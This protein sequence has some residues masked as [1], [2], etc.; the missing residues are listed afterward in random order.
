[1]QSRSPEPGQCTKLGRH[2]REVP[3]PAARASAAHATGPPRSSCASTVGMRKLGNLAVPSMQS[4]AIWSRTPVFSNLCSSVKEEPRSQTEDS[5]PPHRRIRTVVT[6]LAPLSR[7]Y[8]ITR[9]RDGGPRMGAHLS[10]GLAIVGRVAG[11][12]HAVACVISG[13]CCFV[14]MM[15]GC[16]AIEPSWVAVKRG[17]SYYR[18]YVTTPASLQQL[19]SCPARSR[20]RDPAL[21]VSGRPRVSVGS[22]AAKDE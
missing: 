4:R 16:L 11:Q 7:S 19:T 9:R 3:R 10:Q 18:I 1:M 17:L 20:R 15:L 2:S 14:A 22:A 8:S 21:I 12:R 13:E 6:R 5:T